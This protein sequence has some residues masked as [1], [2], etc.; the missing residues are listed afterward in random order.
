[1]RVTTDDFRS[2]INDLIRDNF[3]Q[4]TLCTFTMLGINNS[5]DIVISGININAI[6]I[7]NDADLILL[8]TNGNT[9]KMIFDSVDMDDVT[10]EQTYISGGQTWQWRFNTGDSNT[11]AALVFE[12][13]A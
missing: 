1:M 2:F 10:D 5:V 9:V 8:M 12:M 6:Q 13:A 3:V 7:A 11:Y 4:D